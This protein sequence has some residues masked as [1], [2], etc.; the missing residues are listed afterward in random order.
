MAYHCGFIS[1]ELDICNHL[2]SFK[3]NYKFL[4]YSPSVPFSFSFTSESDSVFISLDKS[5][6]LTDLVLHSVTHTVSD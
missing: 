2:Y 4:K 5:H 6:L 3:F 1:L